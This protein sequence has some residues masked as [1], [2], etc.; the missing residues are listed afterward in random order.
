[1]DKQQLQ[2][3]IDN[4]P[5]YDESK[6]DTMRQWFIDGYSRKMRWITF[7]VFAF[8]VI[9]AIPM[10]IS[11]VGFFGTDQTKY[12]ILYAA[13]FLFCSHWMGFES[14]FAWVMMQRPRHSRERKRLE[15][16]IAELIETIKEK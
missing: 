3:I 10:V 5:Q 16:C 6:E 8:Y 11:V 13:I 1:M 4:P 7:G 2:K 14:V 15:L 9:L 12:Q